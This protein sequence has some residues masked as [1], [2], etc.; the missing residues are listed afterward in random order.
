MVDMFFSTFTNRID[1]KGRVSVPA[2]FR[3]VLTKE[4]AGEVYVNA[5]LGASCLHCFG[6]HYFQ[7]MQKVLDAMDP[8]SP[9]RDALATVIFGET[10]PVSIDADG[11]IVLPAALGQYAKLNEEAAFVGKGDVFEIWEPAALAAQT[12]KARSAVGKLFGG[13]A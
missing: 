8:F 1:K 9:E 3:A 13:K 11:R 10:T 2:P 12:K 6:P 7:K 5:A 4:G